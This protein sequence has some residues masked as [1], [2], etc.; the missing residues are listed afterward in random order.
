[1]LLIIAP[2]GGGRAGVGKKKEARS[3]GATKMATEMATAT[4]TISMDDEAALA[5]DGVGGKTMQMPSA[6]TARAEI[7]GRTMTMTSHNPGY[8]TNQL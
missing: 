1:M 8:P 6:M 5:S 4:M 7:G 3:L 2:T